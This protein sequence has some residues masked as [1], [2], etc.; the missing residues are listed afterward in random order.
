MIP[1]IIE[2]GL[3]MLYNLPSSKNIKNNKKLSELINLSIMEFDYLFNNKIISKEDVDSNAK[4]T[5]WIYK[6]KADLHS[7]SVK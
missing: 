4:G 2:W 6:N 5:I 7:N 1:N 3:N